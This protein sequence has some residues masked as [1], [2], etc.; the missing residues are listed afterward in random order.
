MVDLLS[1]GS[2]RCPA[3]RCRSSGQERLHVQVRLATR[4]RSRRVAGL[5]RRSGRAGRVVGV[6]RRRRGHVAA[7]GSRSP[8]VARRGAEPRGCASGISA[9]DSV[10]ACSP[11][12]SPS[13]CPLPTWIGTRPRRSGSAKLTRPSPPNVVPEQREQ[14]LVLVDRQELAVA[15]RPAL[16]REAEAH[17]PDLGEEGFCHGCLRSVSQGHGAPPVKPPPGGELCEAVPDAPP[18]LP[19]TNVTTAVSSVVAPA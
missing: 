5:Q 9:I 19:A 14:R 12:R 13:V 7:R 6:V 8:P 4:R 10:C 3:G 16:R 11:P 17:D 18:L 15:Q 2:G 1:S